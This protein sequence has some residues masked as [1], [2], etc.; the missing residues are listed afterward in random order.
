[1]LKSTASASTVE[2]V[3]LNV[4]NKNPLPSSRVDLDEIVRVMIGTSLLQT[5][6]SVGVGLLNFLR[7]ILVANLG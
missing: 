6:Y 7:Q 4:N 1:M 5:G 3:R 2:P